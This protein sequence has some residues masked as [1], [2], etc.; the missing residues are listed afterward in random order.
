MIGKVKKMMARWSFKELQKKHNKDLMR[1]MLASV[2]W[3][4][5]EHTVKNQIRNDYSEL[6]TCKPEDVERYRMKVR[7]SID[8]INTVYGLAGYTWAWD[9]YDAPE[10][11]VS[12]DP[13]TIY[14]EPEE[15]DDRV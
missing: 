4:A 13:D 2:P 7:L 8:L 12:S 10:P 15:E 9:K 6:L 3:A 14:K 5:V 11:L 1:E